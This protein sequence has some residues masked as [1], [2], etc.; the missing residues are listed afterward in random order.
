MAEVALRVFQEP[1]PWHTFWVRDGEEALQFLLKETPDYAEAWT[2]DIVLLDHFLPK[3]AGFDVLRKLKNHPK[4]RLIPVVI[5][6]ISMAE[7]DVIE[8]YELGAAAYIPKPAALTE[9]WEQVR[10][11]R[12]FW[13]QALFPVPR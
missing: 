11:V 7:E 13:E 9:L 1:P 8:A 12:R 3:R 2:P 6:A 5:W 10:Q 4:L